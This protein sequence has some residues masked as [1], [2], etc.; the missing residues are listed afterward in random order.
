MTLLKL[1]FFDFSSLPYKR[2]FMVVGDIIGS[3]AILI[4]LFG[5]NVCIVT[6]KECG[7]GVKNSQSADHRLTTES[8][9]AQTDSPPARGFSHQMLRALPF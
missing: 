9:G 7:D 4:Q 6:R 8:V 1:Q 2:L 3:P 5:V